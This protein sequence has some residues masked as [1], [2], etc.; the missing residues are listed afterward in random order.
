MG[1]FLGLPIQASAHAGDIDEMIILIHYLMFI[2]LS[3]GAF[4]SS[5]C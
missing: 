5:G 2:C 1:E 3:D 4:S